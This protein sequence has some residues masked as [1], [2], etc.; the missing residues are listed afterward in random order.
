MLNVSS[1]S[2]YL[3]T[4]SDFS[5]KARRSLEQPLYLL[6]SQKLITKSQS[7]WNASQFYMLI[8]VVCR[9]QFRRQPRNDSVR[10]NAFRLFS[11]R[12]GFNC[13]NADIN[14]PGKTRRRSRRNLWNFPVRINCVTRRRMFFFSCNPPPPTSKYNQVISHLAM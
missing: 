3:L 14:G 7:E 13:A 5:L 1:I 8:S 12:F 4:E 6:Y 11:F 9:T 10:L 2:N